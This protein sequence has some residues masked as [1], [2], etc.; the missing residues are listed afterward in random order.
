MVL[1]FVQDSSLRLVRQPSAKTSLFS[2]HLDKL[3]WLSPSPPKGGA[4]TTHYH[5]DQLEF[6]KQRLEAQNDTLDE[7]H[8]LTYE[9]P[10]TPPNSVFPLM[11]QKGECFLNRVF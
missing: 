9:L 2:P 5:D 8:S 7:G 11:T 3:F 4:P 6:I 1:S 10:Q